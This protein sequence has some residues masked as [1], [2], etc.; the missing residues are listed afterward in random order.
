MVEITEE[1]DDAVVEA[2]EEFMTPQVVPT[3]AVNLPSK[4]AMQ[5]TKGS[6]M[7]VT[8]AFAPP[9]T[10]K[11]KAEAFAQRLQTDP[12]FQKCRRMMRAFQTGN[13]NKPGVLWLRNIINSSHG[14]EKRQIVALTPLKLLSSLNACLEKT[15]ALKELEQPCPVDELSIIYSTLQQDGALQCTTITQ[16]WPEIV[17]KH[18]AFMR[19]PT[20]LFGFFL[21]YPKQS[22]ASSIITPFQIPT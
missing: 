11:A 2:V 1:P 20:V 14:Y 16:L 8:K 17:Q 21:T 15:N 22:S 19:D 3:Q 7:T 9:P 18:S 5:I 4:N 12:T 13:N 6:C 10:A